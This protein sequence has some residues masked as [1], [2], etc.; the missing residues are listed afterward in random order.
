MDLPDAVVALKQCWQDFYDQCAKPVSCLFCDAGHIVW[1]GSRERAATV[2][3]DG[4]VTHFVGVLVRRVRCQDCRSSWALRPP[5]LMPR[6][7]FQL[8]VVSSA[9][10]SY[11]FDL[12]ASM[13]DVAVAHGSSRRTLGRWLH[14][15][16]AVASPARLAAA[17]LVATDAPLAVDLAEH[18]TPARGQSRR[19]RD[20]RTRAARHLT[21]IEA[22]AQALGLEPPGL[23]A[24]VERAVGN[25]DRLTTY[26]RPAI[27]D[28]ARRLGLAD[29][30]MLAG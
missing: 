2:R 9:T 7:H 10:S 24:V 19:S 30:A 17:L 23:R 28:L 16:S 26:A 15:S 18:L 25:R 14:W 29:S 5:G 13:H 4:I 22:L 3:V 1:N 21:L 11:A 20:V 6:R 27:P 8:C 12:D